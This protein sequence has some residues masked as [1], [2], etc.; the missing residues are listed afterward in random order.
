MPKN[1]RDKT[2]ARVVLK[3]GDDV[4]TDEIA[5]PDHPEVTLTQLQE[6]IDYYFVV[7]AYDNSGNESKFSNEICLKIEN[8]SV[9]D[10]TAASSSGGSDGGGGGSGGGVGCFISTLADGHGR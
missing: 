8:A 6:D 3:L 4:S 1:S 10:C 5:D 7:T 2:T 9:T